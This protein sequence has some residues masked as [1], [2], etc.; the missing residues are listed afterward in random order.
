M[1]VALSDMSGNG[2]YRGLT[3]ANGLRVGNPCES[4][5]YP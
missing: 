5:A 1:E 3:E 2:V 4:E